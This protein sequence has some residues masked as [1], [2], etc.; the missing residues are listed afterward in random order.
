MSEAT[1]PTARIGSILPPEPGCRW[2]VHS[3]CAASS[4][5]IL[6]GR[7]RSFKTWLSLD[8]AVSIA[9]GTPCLD[10]FAVERQGPVL[11]F[12]A[13]DSPQSA[14]E[15]VEGI[16][17]HRN[18]DIDLIDLFLITAP[19]IRL[20]TPSDT[21]KLFATVAEIKPLLLVLDP[22]VRIHSGIDE[23]SASEVSRLLATLRLLQRTHDVSILL[24]HHLRKNSRGASGDALR[25]S[26]DLYAWTDSLAT[27]T[28]KGDA[29]ILSVEHR[30]DSPIEPVAVTLVTLPD[31]TCPHLELD[32]EA[33]SSASPAKDITAA[34][35]DLLTRDA[36]LSRT[37]IR[38]RIRVNN[39]RLGSALHDLQA[40][41]RIHRSNKGWSLAPSC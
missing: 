11:L 17:R 40:S 15:R 5:A 20:P 33:S 31:G 35:I 6:A 13:E 29:L 14:R 36:P 21:R 28:H 30:F 18:L 24:I 12:L 38:S 39:N 37:E 10:T 26:G 34:V 7:P 1:L 41:G 27:L 16:C 19:T 9:S 23:N 4:V 32:H 2:L 22:F 3:L 8:L 25:G